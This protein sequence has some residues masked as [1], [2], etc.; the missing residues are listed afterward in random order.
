V[1]DLFN[2]TEE[3][4]ALRR[5]IRDFVER[6]VDP[7]AAAHDRTESFNIDLFRKLGE[8]GVLGVTVPETFGGAGMDAVAA[9]LVHEELS[10]ADPGFTLAYLAHS[11]LFVNNFYQNASDAQRARTLP[12]ACSGK[13]IGGMCMSEPSVGTDVLGMRT[14]AARKGDVYVLNGA[15]MWITNGA[16][17]DTELGDIFLVYARTGDKGT[18]ALSL[19]LVE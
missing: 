12:D 19:F 5:T 8:L 15:K 6:E 18:R 11:M 16:V 17:S 2:P 4:A 14:T 10:A 7:Q 13:K 1:S 3:H 9:V